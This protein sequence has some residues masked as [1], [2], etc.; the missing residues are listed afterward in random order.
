MACSKGVGVNNREG[1]ASA[2]FVHIFVV[3]IACRQEGEIYVH[4]LQIK[5][6]NLRL[7]LGVG[8][9]GGRGRVTPL[10]YPVLCRKRPLVACS[11]I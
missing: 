11:E 8:G 10:M 1:G 6:I 3:H 2:G 7:F 4:V 9:E 5:F